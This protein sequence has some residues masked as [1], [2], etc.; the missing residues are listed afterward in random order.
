[1]DHLCKLTG[2]TCANGGYNAKKTHGNMDLSNRTE[3]EIM[4]VEQM[5]GPLSEIFKNKE[6]SEII[7]DSFD[8]V[9]W[10]QS[11]KILESSDLFKNSEE[12]F[13]VIKNIFRSVGRELEENQG[14]ADCRLEDGT[15]VAAV[16][17]S[18]SL[19][20]PA[21]VIRKLPYHNVTLDNL[22]S[23]NCLDD[24]GAKLIKKIMQKGK[25]V[26][27][28]GNA[29]SGKTTMA[30]VI[31]EQIDPA[32]RVVTVEKTAEMDFKRKRTLRLETPNAKQ[33]E[34]VE[35]LKNAYQLRADYFIVNELVGAEAF[36]S[37]KFMKEGY[38]V[39]ATIMAESCLDAL[40]RIELLSM[41]SSY[42][43]GVEE[44]R[45]QIA[46]GVQIVINQK[47]LENGQRKIVGITAIEGLTDDGK[48][49]MKPLY[50]YDESS[51]SF[52]LTK[53]GEKFLQA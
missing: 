39:L 29:G 43:F 27:L 46:S 20:G 8:D 38:S 15:R 32:W 22:I 34:M 35:L 12:I 45:H 16:F 21:L 2:E 17:G 47:R 40:K 44:L 30:N 9:Y 6:V 13:S 37:V 53:E 41:M 42:G 18:I 7:V 26:V 25:N 36:E 5:M 50:S 4:N 28:A 3:V 33:E 24:N 49:K 31:V 10:E 23:W 51:E 19:N 1:M 14:Y 11:G 48:Y 52:Y